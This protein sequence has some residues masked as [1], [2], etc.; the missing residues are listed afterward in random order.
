MVTKMKIKKRSIKKGELEKG[1]KA[2][3][4]GMVLVMSLIAMGMGYGIAM[5]PLLTTKAC[6]TQKIVA[7][8]HSDEIPNEVDM[9]DP[10]IPMTA[11]PKA[12][13]V[14]D[15]AGCSGI[16]SDVRHI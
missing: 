15:N 14:Y 13:C 5:K 7:P 16:A 3:V 1:N 11:S 4:I 9:V 8:I 2:K 6:D 10:I 12:S